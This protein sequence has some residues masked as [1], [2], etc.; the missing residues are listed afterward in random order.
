MRRKKKRVP[1]S[2]YFPVHAHSEYSYMDGM[3]S[4]ADMVTKVERMN[5][6]ALALTDHGTM[7]GCIRLYKLCRKAGIEPL[8]GSE[9]YL[10]TDRS[11]DEAKNN[12]YH[13]GMLA[14]NQEGWK[15]MIKL[16]S[17]S[18]RRD[19]FHRKPL[20]DLGDLAELSRHHT[21]DVAITT[22]CYFGWIVQSHLRFDRDL[23][24]TAKLVKK[25]AAWFPNTFVEIQYHGI[26]HDDN[27][28]SDVELAADLFQLADMTGL[29]V[30]L[31]QD[32]H[33]CDS[34]D[35]EAHDLMK[36]ICYFGDGEDFS[37]PGGPY[38][39]ASAKWLRKQWTP[40]YWD[41]F[42]EG[43]S[44]LLDKANVRLPALD[45]F[46]F[47]VPK[48]AQNPN[49]VLRKRAYKLALDKGLVGDQTYMDR[50]DQELEVIAQ[51][52]FS[53][54]FLLIQ[55]LLEWCTQEGIIFNVRGSANGSLVCFVI[56]I[57]K[58][59]PLEWNTDF[60]RFLSL[61]RQ[62]PPDIDIDV[63]S[64]RRQDVI[65]WVRTKY[66]TTIHIGTYSRLGFSNAD[67]PYAPDED[68][69]GSV[70]VQYMAAKRRQMGAAFDG[71]VQPGDWDALD[72]LSE[73]D[74]RKSPGVHAGGLVVPGDGLPISDYLATMLIPS[75]ETT[76]TQ[77]VM[78]D[79]EDA[80]Y[81]KIDVLGLRSLST[82]RRTLDL[83]GRDPLE[84]LD[85]I[86]NDD[87]RACMILRSGVSDN[88][89]FQFEGWST[90]KG[91]RQ[92]KVKSTNDAITCLALFRPAMMNSGM[93]DRYLEARDSNT[94]E[95][96]PPEVDH[97]FTDT[98]GVPV[99]QEQV[100]NLMKAVG[101]SYEDRNDILKAVK[102][103][104]DKIG[105]YAVA[106]FD[107]VH[108]VFVESAMQTLGVDEDSAEDMWSTV[109]D[110]SDYGFNRA[111]ATSYGLM[112]YRMAYLKAHHSSAFM[113]ALLATWAGTDK[114]AK[115]VQEAR[116]MK[117]SIGRACVNKSDVVW[118]LD[119]NGVL[120]KGLLSIK[121]IGESAAECIVEERKANGPYQSAQDM[122][123][124][125][126]ARP[127]SGGKNWAKTG[128]PNGIYK[129]L[130]EARALNDVL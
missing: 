50:I 26:E 39:L 44:L 90:A 48:M 7:A 43:H 95:W 103:S 42:E 31:G 97:L 94:P 73:L 14:L 112:A 16:S 86:P 30:V 59:D 102:A 82:V 116:R 17:R 65:G 126:P 71:K 49:R 63:E 75:S 40:E 128:A 107:R 124:R 105:E 2:A 10:V 92:M 87:K 29:P 41:R 35:Q 34:H 111:H 120:R 115:Y 4:V 37:F 28:V 109:T 121:G 70:M 93:T 74:V 110:F 56:G 23:D 88:G 89:V 18:Y 117:M 3:G 46:K 85:W 125:L 22:G 127:I 91:A 122:I 118:T 15:A 77:A 20:I 68:R 38:H 123:D 57:T 76:C 79:V 21:D 52:D 81:T 55:E 6:P 130:M 72:K 25:L 62:K 12:R 8:P 113:A 96:N 51:M 106:T 67:D 19:R 78:E 47:H 64:D 9:F 13:M 5:Q 101:L 32:S 1:S 114:E 36:D 99:F 84:G 45:T 98:Y 60:D 66:P 53:D 129:V 61:D 69:K 58:V 104:N 108:P 80:G 54:Y 33:Y 83:I 24:R 27:D 119:G 11:D 100:L